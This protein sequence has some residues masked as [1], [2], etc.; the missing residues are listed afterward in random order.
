MVMEKYFPAGTVLSVPSYT[1]HHDEG[2]RGDDVQTVPAG[3]S[4]SITVH[5]L[6]AQLSAIQGKFR[7]RRMQAK[8]LV[9]AGKKRN[10]ESILRFILTSSEPDHDLAILLLKSLR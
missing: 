10:A 8:T 1:I 7:R 2:I 4:V 3:K 9:Y 6:P 5:L